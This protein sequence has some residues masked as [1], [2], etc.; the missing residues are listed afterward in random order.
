[1]GAH[2]CESCGKGAFVSRFE[3]DEGTPYYCYECSQN[4]RPPS[5]EEL[6][7]TKHTDDRVGQSYVSFSQI[8]REGKYEKGTG[9]ITVTHKKK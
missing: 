2:K 4:Q 9:K 6:R 8:Y 5:M 7:N 1:M 3:E